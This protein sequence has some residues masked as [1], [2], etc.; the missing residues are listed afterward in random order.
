MLLSYLKNLNRRRLE[1][2]HRLQNERLSSQIKIIRDCITISEQHKKVF[3]KYKNIALG[4]DVAIVATGKT[5]EQF[6]PEFLSRETI[7]IGVNR[8]VFFNKINYDYLFIQDYSGAKD[9]LRNISEYQ[10]TDGKKCI[11]LYGR[12]IKKTDYK[13]I[14]PEQEYLLANANLYYTAYPERN[15]N[16]DI[17]TGGLADLESVVFAALNFALWMHPKS[18]S[19]VGCDCS[20]IYFDNK[21]TSRDFSELLDGWMIA[22]KFQMG[23]YPDIKIYS[24][25]PVGLR[26]IFIDKYF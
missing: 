10:R 18:I 23:F 1:K 21:K 16:Y 3:P 7:Y 11:K 19:L 4:K 22:R 25:N 8:A 9:Y 6:N 13:F 20:S 5:L 12:L 24:I 15:F 2:R 26:E 14:I 17:S